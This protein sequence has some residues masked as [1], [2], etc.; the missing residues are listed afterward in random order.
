MN[1]TIAYED[2]SARNMR[3]WEKALFAH[4]SCWCDPEESCKAIQRM[5]KKAA[6]FKAKHPEAI[7]GEI[8]KCDAFNG[9]VIISTLFENPANY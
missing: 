8:M 6:D 1:I 3:K 4:I 7:G 5:Q 2:D 9:Q